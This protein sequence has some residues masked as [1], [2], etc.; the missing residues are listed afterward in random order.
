MRK[1]TVRSGRRLCKSIVFMLLASMLFLI[2]TVTAHAEE[3]QKSADVYAEIDK[4]VE[5]F[6]TVTPEG[7]QENADLKNATETLGIKRILMSVFTVLTDKRGELVSLLLTLVG[8]ALIGSLSSVLE[9]E[10]GAF[11]SRA[12]GCVCAALL[13]ERLSFLVVSSVKS[14]EEIGEYFAAVVPVCLAVNSL[15]ASPTTATAQALG[16][17]ITLSIYSY[18]SSSVMLPLVSTVFVASAASS[19]DATLGRLAKGIKSTFLWV[20]GI[21]STLV[22]ATFSLQSVLSASADSAAIRSA[23]YAISSTVPVVGSSVSGALGMLTTGVSYARGIVGGGAVAVILS[24]ILSPLVTLLLYRTCLKLGVLFSS[25][26]SSD[27]AGSVLSAFLGSVDVLI[28]AYTLTATVYL[29]ELVA[30]LK[31]GATFA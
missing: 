17:G 10:T 16:M 14:L 22:S 11:S 27:G 19:V 4:I 8:V 1:T 9:T 3:T 21:F 30:F 31:G 6:V 2:P 18:L 20:M 23:R 5:N 29:V 13:F 15:G 24:L 25:V 28:A 26:I 12:V 7:M